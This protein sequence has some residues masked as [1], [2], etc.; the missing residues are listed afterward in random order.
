MSDPTDG[1]DEETAVDD[2]RRIREQLD[3]EAGGDIDRLAERAR[4]VSEQYIR[5]LGLKVVQPPQRNRRDGA[6]G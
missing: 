1:R 2:V 3:R 5:E 4:Q 6:V